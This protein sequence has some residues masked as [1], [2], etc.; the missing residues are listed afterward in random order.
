VTI[1]LHADTQLAMRGVPRWQ[2]VAGF[3]DA[4]L[5]A[6]YPNA[7]PNSKVLVRQLLPDGSEAVAV[8]AYVRSIRSAKL[9]TLYF[10]E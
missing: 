2:T 8:W 9:V 5:I 3:I 1:S 10:E 7:V 6:E 4:T